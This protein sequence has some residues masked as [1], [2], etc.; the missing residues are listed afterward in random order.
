MTH[1]WRLPAGRSWPLSTNELLDALDAADVPHPST[2]QR[3]P[4]PQYPRGDTRVLEVE[5][6][7]MPPAAM[8]GWGGGREHVTVVINNTPSEQRLAVRRELLDRT[9]PELVAWL[10]KAATE[11]EGWRLLPHRR[12]WRWSNGEVVAEDFDDG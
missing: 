6:Q 2:V 10:G 4:N 12:V 7:P 11:R 3:I 9:V 5:W 8:H 1:R